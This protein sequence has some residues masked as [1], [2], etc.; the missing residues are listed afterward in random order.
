VEPSRHTAQ[1]YLLTNATDEA[2]ERLATAIAGVDVAALLILPGSDG[3]ID[4]TAALKLVGM[5]QRSGVAVLIQDDAG[6]AVRLGSDGVHLAAG[7]D[8]ESRYK[9]ARRILGA[10][11]I[12]GAQVGKSR[13]DAMVLGEAGADYIGFGIP[14]NVQDRDGARKR[15][16]TLA[17]WWAEI[18]E[19]P[20]VAFDVETPDEAAALASAGVDFIGVRVPQAMTQSDL[21]TLLNGLQDACK[22]TEQQEF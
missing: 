15:R 17:E 19:P 1:L 13:H 3:S 9:D 12:V 22:K 16:D 21:R 20:C 5:A 10:E 14:A 11:A 7:P 8:L 4:M 18:F 2:A 6:L